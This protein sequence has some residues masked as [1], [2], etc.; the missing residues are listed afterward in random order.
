MDYTSWFRALVF[1]ALAGLS[2]QTLPAGVVTLDAA[3]RGY[4]TLDPIL[5]GS[6]APFTST[7][8]YLAGVCGVNDCAGYEDR[9]YFTFNIPALS[10]TVV[11]ATLLLDTVNII[12][13]DTS[14]TYQ[15]TSASAS[16]NFSTAGNGTVYG[17][18]SYTPSESNTISSITLDA[19]ALAAIVSNTTFYVSGRITTLTGQTATDEFAFGSSGG[20]GFE[21]ELQ[22]VTS[23]SDPSVPEPA[24]AAMLLLGLAS[25]ALIRRRARHL[26]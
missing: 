11:S 22:I 26:P 3:T 12:T 10:G 5:T 2:Q 9:N 8:N 24:S 4:F 14:D 17:S 16:T 6:N 13:P 18:I 1:V 25:L 23:S 7:N 20:T 21:T 15:V 19:A